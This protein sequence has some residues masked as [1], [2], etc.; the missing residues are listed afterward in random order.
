MFGSSR[1]ARRGHAAGGAMEVPGT[2]GHVSVNPNGHSTAPAHGHHTTTGSR[3]SSGPARLAA[4]FLGG[5]RGTTST[6]TTPA[7]TTHTTGTHH[8]TTGTH[9]PLSMKIKRA[10]GMGPSA[11]TTSASRRHY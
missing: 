4:K 9:M 11:H 1:T 10:M 7:H 3:R 2:H 5:S 8:A 6:H